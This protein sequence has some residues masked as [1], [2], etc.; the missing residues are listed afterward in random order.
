MSV[1][2]FASYLMVFMLS[3]TPVEQHAYYERAEVTTAR[4]V[5]ISQSLAQVMLEQP[6]PDAERV[7]VGAIMVLIGNEE[8]HWNEASVSCA[9]GG[10]NG[11]AW[12]PWQTQLPKENVCR[13]VAPAARLAV[14]MVK[15]S[16]LACKHLP[17]PGRLSWYTD[18]GSWN[19]SPSRRA[20][21]FKRSE[22][23]MTRALSWVKEHP[24]ADALNETP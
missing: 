14:E 17:P 22:W 13:G 5:D 18:G 15:Q 10:D 23:R 20:R 6:M 3:L 8:S 4:Y 7:K 9:K 2:A 12:G 24:F 1:A 19:V 16:F 21:A 11:K